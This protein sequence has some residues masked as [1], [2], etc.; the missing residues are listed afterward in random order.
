MYKIKIF[1]PFA[2]SN[3]CKEIY[4]KI[5]YTNEIEFYGKDKKIYNAIIL[6]ILDCN[7]DLLFLVFG[8]LAFG[9]LVTLLHRFLIVMVLIVEAV[10]Y[11]I[12]PIFLIRLDFFVYLCCQVLYI[13]F[14]FC[15]F[16]FLLFLSSLYY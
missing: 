3:R 1:C 6:R 13:L 8:F 15:I 4:E 7:V 9:F 5:N 10:L 14:C 11:C 16:H 12:Y 2:Q